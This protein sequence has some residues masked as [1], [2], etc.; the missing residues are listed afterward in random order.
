MDLKYACLLGAVQ[1]NREYFR[2]TRSELDVSLVALCR[3]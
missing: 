2:F 1:N 3:V